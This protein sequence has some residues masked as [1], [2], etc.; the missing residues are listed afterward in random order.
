M[1]INLF[2]EVYTTSK[3]D[4]MTVLNTAE[5]AALACIII[6]K[7]HQTGEVR[8]QTDTYGWG[9]VEGNKDDFDDLITP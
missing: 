7:T 8:L 9:G 1:A 6:L 3:I 2:Q 4:T 5:Y